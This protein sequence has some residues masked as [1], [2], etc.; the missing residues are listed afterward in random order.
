MFLSGL[1]EHHSEGTDAQESPSGRCTVLS[2]MVSKQCASL[3]TSTLLCDLSCLKILLITNV[4]S[5]NCLFSSD[6]EIV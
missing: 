2:A 1:L 3:Q 6:H 5:K 4:A